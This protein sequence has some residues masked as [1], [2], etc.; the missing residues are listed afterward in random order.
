MEAGPAE[1]RWDAGKEGAGAG[2]DTL[3]VVIDSML[4]LYSAADGKPPAFPNKRVKL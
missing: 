3:P 2:G 1:V 4:R